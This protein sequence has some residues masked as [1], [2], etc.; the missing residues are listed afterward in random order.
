[1]IDKIYEMLQNVPNVYFGWYQ[2]DLNETHVTFFIY[3]SVP[4]NFSDNEY[5]SIED[6]IQVDVWG[7]DYEEVNDRTIEVREIFTD[8]GFTWSSGNNDFETDTKI[9]HNSLR[10]KIYSE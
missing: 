4:T 6:S 1:M 7:T 3:N 5:E 9:F 8:N 10:F 2:E